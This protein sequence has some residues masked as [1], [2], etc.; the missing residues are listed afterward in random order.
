MSRLWAYYLLSEDPQRRLDARKVSTLAHQVSL[1]RHILDSEPHLNRVLI[2][3]E[4]GLGKT[5]EVGLLVKEWLERNDRLRVLYLAPARLVDNVR[6]EF[7]RLGLGFRQWSASSEVDGRLDDPRLIASIHRA[8]H[9]KHFDALLSSARWDVVIVDECH[10]LSDWSPGGGDPTRK[11]KLVRELIAK[12]GR[13]ARVVLLSGTPHQGNISRFENLLGL[14]KQ[15]D[16]RDQA[17][18]GRVIYRTKEDVRDWDGQPLFPGRKVAKPIVVDL[19]PE[20]R[21]WI[22]RIHDFFAPTKSTSP[23]SEP[24]RRSENWRCAQALQWAASSPQAG[25]GY[26][27][28]QAVRAGGTPSNRPNLAEALLTLRPYRMGPL[29][30]PVESL[31]QRICKEIDRQRQDADI[32]D[33]EDADGELPELVSPALD[34]LLKDG[35]QLLRSTPDDK[36]SILKERILDPAGMEKIVLFAQPIETVTAL[37]SYLE[38]TTGI[39]PSL[40]V[41]G[42]KDSSRQREI[43]AFRNPDGPRYLVSSRAGGEGINLQVSRRIVHLDVPWNPMDMEQRVGRVHRFGSRQTILVDTLVVKNSREEAAY[44]VAREKLKHISQVM[45]DQDK[46]EALFSRVMNLIPPEEFIGVFVHKPGEGLTDEQQKKL[47]EMVQQGYNSWN[48]FNHRFAGQQRAIRALNPGLATWDDMRRF[49]AE[50]CGAVSVEGFRALRF[51]PPDPTGE[52]VPVEVSVPVVKLPDG[53]C[54]LGQE[55]EG[56]PVSGPEGMSVEDLGLNVPVLA[57]LLRKLALSSITTGAAHL[58]WGEGRPPSPLGA[59]SGVLVLLRQTLRS[60][61]ARWVEHGLELHCYHVDESGKWG[62]WIGEDRKAAL[63]SMLKAIVRREP[64]PDDSLLNALARCETEIIRLL[65]A[66]ANDDRV[67]NMRHSILPLLAA[68][69]SV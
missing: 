26:L 3:D 54:Y 59:T 69:I 34:L 4:V 13:E 19:G 31:F 40:I 33:M 8:I 15:D 49:L 56:M 2:A 20:Y 55:H 46:F 30:E 64:H 48:E 58:R 28:R 65:R 67:R 29:D 24:R 53:S 57:E 52:T 39:R 38:R 45:V 10:H 61:G 50:Q 25:L 60:E 62:E 7:D 22:E 44:R 12:Q 14:L 41:G 37:A 43:E 6:W 63:S 17:M 27:V 47:A 5:I 23:M 68:I 16:E 9:P 42:Q 1:V 21:D 18:A 51:T 36:W 35:I 66:P 11:F 32:E